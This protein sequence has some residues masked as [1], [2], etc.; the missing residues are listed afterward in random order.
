[1]KMVIKTRNENGYKEEKTNG[2]KYDK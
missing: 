2:E 1:M